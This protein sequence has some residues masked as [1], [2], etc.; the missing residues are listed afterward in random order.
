MRGSGSA[1][2]PR[3]EPQASR[4]LLARKLSLLFSFVV[5]AVVVVVVAVIL[6][7]RVAVEHLICFV[8]VDIMMFTQN[9]GQDIA[10]V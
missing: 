5:A 6:L 10:E 7:S 8:L 3:C 4:R 2:T 1:S 9:I